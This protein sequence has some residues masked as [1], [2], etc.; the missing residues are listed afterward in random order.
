MYDEMHFTRDA[1]T[2]MPD[3]SADGI[4]VDEDTGDVEFEWDKVE[5]VRIDDV[6]WADQ[7]ET[8]EFYKIPGT[9]ARP[10]KQPYNF[11]KD[12]LILKKPRQELKRA[13]WSLDNAPWT[14]GHP[15]TGMVK[16]VDD[17]RGFWKNPRYIDSMDELQADLHF[18]VG[19]EEARDYVEDNGDVSVGFYNRI[20]RVDMYDGVVGGN[21]D[22][23]DVDGFQTDMYFDHVA[24]VGIG[25]C[26]SG[27]GC[28]LSTDSR[29]GHVESALISDT[30]VTNKSR[31]SSAEGYDEEAGQSKDGTTNNES[32]T[33][34]DNMTEQEDAN[35]TTDCGGAVDFGLDDLTVDAIASQHNGVQE[36]KD[37]LE[38]AREQAEKAE[39]VA[40]TLELDDGQSITD[41][42]GLLTDKLDTLQ[43]KVDEYEGS[44]KAELIEEIT[45]R[46]DRWDED[47]LED[48]SLETVQDRYD[49]VMELTAD[50]QTAN[51]GGEGGETPAEPV[52]RQVPWA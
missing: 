52:S 51:S 32:E 19:D 2:F 15:D 25:R 38:T 11:G 37:E 40:E 31:D 26:P 20:T 30:A 13:A 39:A 4:T 33:Q 48:E 9:V 43:E 45:E 34:T 24:S 41:A 23:E 28:G 3:G 5:R 36:L 27:K 46:T 18:P 21:D 29:H 12:Q 42:V 6:P 22:H 17:I 14:L 16:H 50:E 35:E 7:F 10:I 47:E 44:E 49:L 1:S 8:N